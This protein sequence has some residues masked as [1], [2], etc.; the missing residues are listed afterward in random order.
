MTV[1]STDISDR[2]TQITVLTLEDLAFLLCDEGEPADCDAPLAAASIVRFQGP[3][4]GELQIAC[5]QDVL[6]DLTMNLLGDPAAVTEQLQQDAL[7]EV[8][9]IVCGNLL[10]HVFGNDA[11]FDLDRPQPQDVSGGVSGDSA[12][13]VAVDMG[14]VEVAFTAR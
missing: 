2:L 5:T 11:V 13:Q 12:V 9:N 7:G 10:P 14:R 4:T 3:C 8:A 1:L 6:D